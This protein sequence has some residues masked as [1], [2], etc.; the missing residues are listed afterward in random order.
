[1]E[2]A[3]RPT[4]ARVV[5]AACALAAPATFAG[6][7]DAALYRFGSSLTARANVAERH[8]A[9]VAFWSTSL[10]G[11]RR[12]RVRASGQIRSVRL[13]G[14]ALRA[15]GGPKPLTEFHIQV[16]QP[17]RDGRVRVRLTSQPFN[18]PYTGD[19][20]QITTYRP[21]NLCARRGDYV[22]FNDEG[23]FHPRWY[24]NGVP[25]QVFS[26]VSG[27]RTR[28]FT[29]AG[30]TNNGDRF[31]GRVRRGRELLMQMRLGT[32]R[33]VSAACRSYLR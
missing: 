10:A 19:S 16:L 6:T 7:A 31:R 21:I 29:G 25:Y 5:L 8:G 23:G 13:K 22:A 3:V 32:G 4:R 11:R 33:H 26:R 20:Q 9:D 28:F 2:G 15:A 30:A 14:I 18:I 24:P 1:M 17:L 27:S 12:V